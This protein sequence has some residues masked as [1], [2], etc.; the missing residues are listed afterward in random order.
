MPHVNEVFAGE[1]SSGY[2]SPSMQPF[3]KTL[4]IK[5]NVL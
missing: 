2:P 1:S 3:A 4:D 5:V